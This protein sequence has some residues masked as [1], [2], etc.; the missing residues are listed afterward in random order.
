MAASQAGNFNLQE[1]TDA[2]LLLFGGR[3]YTYTYG[4]TT[5][6][7]AY[8]DAANTIPHTYTAD[9]SGGQYIA[10]N[11]RG[12]LPAPLYLVSGSYDLTLKRADGSIIWTRR[13]DGVESLAVANAASLASSNGSSLI[14][15]LQSGANAVPSFAQDKLRESVS[16]RDFGAKGDGVTD[17][18]LSIQ[19][20]INYVQ[21]TY[22]PGTSTSP[23][24]GSCR[25]FFPAGY[26]ILTDKLKVSA[27]IA[28][29]GEGQSEFSS[30]S[31]L[32]QTVA[33]K[34]IFALDTTV[35]SF[36]ISIEKLTLKST[37]AGSGHLVNTRD[38]GGFKVNSQ[39]YIGCTFANP[40][41]Q[42]LLLVGDDIVVENCLFDVSGYSGMAIQ[43]GTA[44]AGQVASNVSIFGCNFFNCPVRCIIIYNAYGICIDANRVTQPSSAWKTGAFVDAADAAPVLANRITV[45]GNMLEGVNRIFDGS[46][47][48][49]VAITGNTGSLMGA[50]A[51]EIYNCIKANGTCSN[52]TVSGNSISGAYDT[53]NYVNVTGVTGAVVSG[54]NFHATSGTGAAVVGTGATGMLSPNFYRGFADNMKIIADDYSA[55]GYTIPAYQIVIYSASITINMALGSY[56]V[57]VPTDG[58]AFTINA[59]L[60]PSGGMILRF[61]IFNNFGVLGAITWNAVFKKNALVNPAAGFSKII[62]F[63]Y[64]SGLAAWSEESRSAS[65]IPN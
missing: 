45:S 37:I 63:I 26:Y 43:L 8:T 64:S 50:G 48:N 16:V 23:W 44:T 52:I 15:F 49:D 17:D 4:T 30:G 54:N 57:V 58:V 9:G 24:N 40:Q 3:L 56:A 36:S 5:Q 28:L 61:Q 31:R 51:G 53:K 35:A 25:L 47:V 19:R 20:A 38:V 60:S 59:P 29:E 13:A 27:K 22:V 14:G 1:F 46:N 42:S 62:T 33:N 34:D 32:V 12:E 21:G 65:D 41:Q 18:T 11:A 2:G 6:K 55:V 10:I 7:T 39:R